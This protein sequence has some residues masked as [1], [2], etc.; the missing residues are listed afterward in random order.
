MAHVIRELNLGDASDQLVR[1]LSQLRN[2][3]VHAAG[4]NS[5]STSAA[6]NYIEACEQ[7]SEAVASKG[8]SKMQHPSR[9]QVWQE[10][11]QQSAGFW[12]NGA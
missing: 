8:R 9:S 2:E 11:R 10:L 3:F 4:Q 7:L 6:L 5:I 12:H 1:E